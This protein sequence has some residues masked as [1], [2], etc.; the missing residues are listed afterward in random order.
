MLSID[1]GVASCV[2]LVLDRE[3]LVRVLWTLMSMNYAYTY[4]VVEFSGNY[5]YT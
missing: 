1:I 5:R 2:C 4:V 3:L